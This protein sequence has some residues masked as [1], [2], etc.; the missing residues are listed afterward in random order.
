MQRNVYSLMIRPSM[1]KQH[2]RK[3]WQVF[4]SV[5]TRS[6]CAK[7]CEHTVSG[8]EL[9]FC[10]RSRI[11][12]L[13]PLSGRASPAVG[14][15]GLRCVQRNVY[16]LM[17]RPSMWKQHS[18]KEWQVFSS[19]RTRSSCAKTCEHT[20]SGSELA[21]CWRSRIRRLLPLFGR[22]SPAVGHTLP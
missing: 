22:A 12:R 1:W 3:E 10:W 11:R 6:S 4:S 9:A 21:F 15:R 13:L 2:S 14:H 18:R 19:V 16:S 7:T 8:S 17:I 5:R 20:M